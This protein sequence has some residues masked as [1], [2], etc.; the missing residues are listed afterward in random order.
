MQK[1][2][3]MHCGIAILRERDFDKG[4]PR[5]KWFS[6]VVVCHHTAISALSEPPK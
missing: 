4:T 6:R 1:Y 2:Y 3:A 5:L